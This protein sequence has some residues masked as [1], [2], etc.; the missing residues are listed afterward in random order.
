MSIS[1]VRFQSSAKADTHELGIPK[2]VKIRRWSSVTFY[3]LSIQQC[4]ALT[5]K[6]QAPLA[7][8]CSFQLDKWC[9]RG[10]PE[11]CE[12]STSSSLPQKNVESSLVRTEV[13]KPLSS[14]P[15][16]SKVTRLA[17]LTAR[18]GLAASFNSA[19]NGTCVS[20]YC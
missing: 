8:I 3:P 20:S 14:I 4:K 17:K 6:T 10:R 13:V 1:N 12:H 9:Y 7:C 16:T 11:E 5:S 18:L 15:P 19:E 2:P